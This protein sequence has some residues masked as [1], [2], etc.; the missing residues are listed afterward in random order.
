MQDLQK[1]VMF[2]AL[3]LVASYTKF[4]QMGQIFFDCMVSIKQAIESEKQNKV[5][6]G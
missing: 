5:L 2:E 3:G 6:I 1:M 4:E